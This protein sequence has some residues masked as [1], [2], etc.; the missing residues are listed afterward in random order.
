[1]SVLV[2]NRVQSGPHVNEV[3]QAVLIAQ[4][5]VADRGKKMENKLWKRVVSSETEFTWLPPNI[6]W[7]FCSHARGATGPGL[8]ELC[9]L[10]FT[11]VN[12]HI[13]EVHQ[14]TDFCEGGS[15]TKSKP[16]CNA[17]HSQISKRT[18]RYTGVRKMYESSREPT[19]FARVFT[20]RVD[21]EK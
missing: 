3:F 1:M 4:E 15:S 10:T 9:T 2:C 12:A 7:A 21:P 19:R 20:Q 16:Q 13:A 5:S 6:P 14:H 11:G 8:Q 18:F 17:V